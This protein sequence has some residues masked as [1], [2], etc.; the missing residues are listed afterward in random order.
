MRKFALCLLL[1]SFSFSEICAD[2]IDKKLLVDSAARGE[3][4]QVKAIIESGK[5][6]V[7]SKLFEGQILPLDLLPYF[8]N[9]LFKGLTALM[10]A[11]Q[12]GHAEIVKYLLSQ[13]ADANAK[14]NEKGFAPLHFAA[15]KGDVEIAKI[16]LDNG[17]DINSKA[18]GWTPVLI[19]ADHGNARLVQFLISQGAIIDAQE[20]EYFI[21]LENVKRFKPEQFRRIE[22]ILLSYQKSR[23]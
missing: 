9:R 3:L 22:K 18:N 23:E 14:E 20:P 11:V 16:L 19:A 4:E 1:F 2:K 12:N 21:V 17:A 13:G 7:D 6:P 10:K 15:T 5:L 8:L